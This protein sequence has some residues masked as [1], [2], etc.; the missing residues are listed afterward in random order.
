MTTRGFLLG[1]F[2]PPHQG[3]VFL[4]EFARRHCDSLTILVC[5]LARDPIP[6]A[7]R[8]AWMRELF[9]DCRVIP[10]TEDGTGRA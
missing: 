8:F 6:G 3:H 7:L 5:S 4:A 1:K 2:L 10:F 9:P